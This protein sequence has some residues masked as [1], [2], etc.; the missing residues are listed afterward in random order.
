M[1]QGEQ[2]KMR[3]LGRTGL[4][5]SSVCLGTMTWGEQNTEAEAHEQLTYAVEER[6]INFIDAAE[7]YPVPPRPET[8][9]RT[10]ECI[11]TW[12]Q[13]RGKRDDVVIATKV[14]GRSGMT[15]VRDEKPAGGLTRHTAEQI[16]EAVEKSLRRLRT[17][18][19]DLLQLHWPDRAY[20]GFGFHA[21]TDYDA[22]DM[23]PLRT[24][25]ESLDRHVKAGRVRHIGISNES[26]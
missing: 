25:L 4:E 21:Y 11:G 3:P 23:V 26:A 10:E 16:D 14:T 9:G 20:P 18:Y 12:L 24:I 13:A 22:D 17:D 15:W 5:V 6:G 7:M 2:M 1:K 8:Q 19:I